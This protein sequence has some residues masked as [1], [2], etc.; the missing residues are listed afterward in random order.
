MQGQEFNEL[1]ER[2][3]SNEAEVIGEL[4]KDK[5][6]KPI[7]VVEIA[8]LFLVVLIGLPI[9]SSMLDNEN[10]MLSKLLNKNT[11][12]TPIPV[13]T[14]A[15]EYANGGTLQVLKSTTKMK[16]QNIIMSDF[17]LSNSNLT[18]KIS[19]YN[20]EINLDEMDAYLEI[21]SSSNTLLGALKLTG[22]YDFQEKE[23]VLQNINLHFN[24]EYS[25]TG[26]I[27]LMKE[28]DYPAIEL[29]TDES[30]IGSFKCTKDNQTIEYIFKNQ[31]LIQL[32]DREKIVAASLG[33]DEYMNAKRSLETKAAN[34][35]NNFATVEE[36]SDGLLYQAS[37]DL[38]T[39]GY[40]IPDTVSDS[41][42]YALDTQA[43]KI[44]YALLG[45]GYDCR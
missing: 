4:R 17:S 7:L 11:G 36:V 23:V 29:S 33:T 30:G 38:E 12:G 45:K 15:S 22:S 42:Y 40:K 20:G 28:D 9:V 44:Q 2:R 3:V 27:V 41:N 16:F 8:V 32:K 10:S 31:Y 26:K 19:S 37:I 6:G 18:C 14:Q 21:Y 34:L 1:N 5:I 35:G 25:Y 24:N 39:P 43:K 13:T